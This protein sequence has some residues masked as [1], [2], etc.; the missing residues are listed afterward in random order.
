MKRFRRLKT[1]VSKVLAMWICMY[2]KD[3]LTERQRN[4]NAEITPA[5]WLALTKSPP[6]Q[7]LSLNYLL[8]N[9]LR[10]SPLRNCERGSAAINGPY[11]FLNDRTTLLLPHRVGFCC[12]SHLQSLCFHM[13]VKK[14]CLPLE[15]EVTSLSCSSVMLI[16]QWINS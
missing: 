16:K 1:G 6:L 4:A 12:S 14:R 8:M 9:R 13:E 7:P 2:D 10:Y 15:K 11:S 3:M 5:V